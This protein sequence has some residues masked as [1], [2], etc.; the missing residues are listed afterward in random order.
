MATYSVIA[1]SELAVN[2]PLTSSLMTRLSDNPIAI[3]EQLG[4]NTGSFKFTSAEQTITQG[5]SLTIN[6]NMTARPR[7]VEAWLVCKIAEQGYSVGDYLKWDNNHPTSAGTN[8]NSISIVATSTQLELRY[9][10]SGPL[11][12]ITK[13]IGQP[14]LLTN[15]NWKLVLEAF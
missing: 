13:N 11:F 12:A 2:K 8:G 15:A 3:F 9:G 10:N 5:G 14:V 7:F 6:H 4:W 1:G